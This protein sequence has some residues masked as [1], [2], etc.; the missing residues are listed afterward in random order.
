MEDDS[1]KDE[2]EE[3]DAAEEQDAGNDEPDAELAGSSAGES[4]PTN[5]SQRS[6]QP[7]PGR[8]NAAGSR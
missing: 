3:D 2:A 1:E 5:A 4:A 7:R 8:R 6:A